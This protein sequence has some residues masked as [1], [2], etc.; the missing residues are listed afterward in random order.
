M[1][2]TTPDL[3]PL[4]QGITRLANILE[5]LNVRYGIIGGIAAALHGI[6]RATADVDVLFAI[7]KIRLAAFLDRLASEGFSFPRQ[8]VLK[9]L[10][11]DGLSQVE[12]QKRRVDLFMPVL[13]FFHKALERTLTTTFFGQPI[14]VVSPEDLILFKLIAF[15][16]Q[17]QQDIQAILAIKGK[18]GLQL[19]YLREWARRMVRPTDKKLKQLEDWLRK[20]A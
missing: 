4:V 13:P 9:E 17:D 11:K 3:S 5:E 19:D 20:L 6:P 16:P 18:T 7:E 12:F 14:R 15:R 8:E 2:S 1:A 10:S